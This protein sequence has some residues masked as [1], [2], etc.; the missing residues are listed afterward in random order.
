MFVNLGP[1]TENLCDKV[2]SGFIEYVLQKAGVNISSLH[3]QVDCVLQPTKIALGRWTKVNLTMHNESATDTK[4]IA[5]KISGPAKILPAN[6][7]STVRAQSHVDIEI[8]IM[9]ME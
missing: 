3:S 7:R 6:I 4:D 8:A 9:P 2:D 1:S 5:V